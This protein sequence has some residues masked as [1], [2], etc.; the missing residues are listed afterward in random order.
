MSNLKKQFGKPCS[1]TIATLAQNIKEAFKRK[2]YTTNNS[3]R[4]NFYDNDL[5]LFTSSVNPQY[6]LDFFAAYPNRRT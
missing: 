2:F 5:F 3:T 4:L 1:T 6:R